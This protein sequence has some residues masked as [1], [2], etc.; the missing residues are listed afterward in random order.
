MKLNL[1]LFLLL[2]CISSLGATT[3]VSKEQAYDIDDTLLFLTSKIYIFEKGTGK[4]LAISTRDYAELGEYVGKDIELPDALRKLIYPDLAKELIGIKSLA[5]FEFKA[6]PFESLSEFSDFSDHSTFLTKLEETLKTKSFSE[7]LGP[8]FWN[9][10][11]GCSTLEDSKKRYFISARGHAPANIQQGFLMLADIVWKKMGIRFFVPPVE[12]FILV[13]HPL[14]LHLGD[15][16]EHRKLAALEKI[17]DKAQKEAEKK[18]GAAL[19]T[20]ADD[21]F[22]NYEKVRDGLKSNMW[23]WP[24]VRIILE[25]VGSVHPGQKFHDFVLKKE[26]GGHT[27]CTGFYSL[28][29]R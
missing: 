19:V 14:Y 26:F 21:D 17:L 3:F 2:V 6:T 7:V 9:L 13:T 18:Q 12:N 5:R 29:Q 22:Q 16:I 11:K 23:K 24:N 27:Q 28:F 10:V 8:R 1:G 20:F 15:S 4:K 25:Y